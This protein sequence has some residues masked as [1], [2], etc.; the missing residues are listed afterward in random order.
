MNKKTL[1]FFETNE[2]VYNELAEK[3]TIEILGLTDK[4]IVYAKAFETTK[5]VELSNIKNEILKQQNEKLTLWSV[6]WRI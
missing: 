4:E 2:K 1:K 5:T 3:R 6:L